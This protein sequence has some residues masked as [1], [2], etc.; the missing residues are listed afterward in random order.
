MIYKVEFKKN[1]NKTFEYY[2]SSL[3]EAMIFHMG[4]IKKGFTS[5]LTRMKL[6]GK[7]CE[8]GEKKWG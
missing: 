5:N 2:F 4:V 7:E 1:T 6:S 8:V 3:K